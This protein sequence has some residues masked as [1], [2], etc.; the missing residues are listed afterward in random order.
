MEWLRKTALPMDDIIADDVHVDFIKIDVEGAELGVLNGAKR[1]IDRCKP[2]LLFEHAKVHNTEYETTPDMVYEFLV[3]DCGLDVFSLNMSGPLSR[4]RFVAIIYESFA[5]NYD[6]HAQTNFIACARL[7]V[8][9][10]MPI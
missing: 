2:V 3:D 1:T 4:D 8:P 9:G 5:S 10:H 6:R 7:G